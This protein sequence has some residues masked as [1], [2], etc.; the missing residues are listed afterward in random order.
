MP[1]L[2]VCGFS[3]TGTVQFRFIWA[4]SAF[5][6]R[7]FNATESGLMFQD[8]SARSLALLPI[9]VGP[10]APQ[11]LQITAYRLPLLL[12]TVSTAFDR[13]KGQHNKSSKPIPSGAASAIG[14]VFG[15]FISLV[16]AGL[17][18]R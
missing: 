17:S 9:V 13:Q 6:V 4:G 3:A 14:N 2:V 7:A 18:P 12:R 16:R 1:A 10:C 11:S 8:F 15:S 5:P